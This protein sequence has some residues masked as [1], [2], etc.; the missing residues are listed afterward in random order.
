VDRCGVPPEPMLSVAFDAIEIVGPP[1]D[2]FRQG[3]E[4][5]ARLVRGGED[6]EVDVDRAPSPCGAPGER[7]RTAE[8]ERDPGVVE[9][10]GDGQHLLGNS[11][12][13]APNRG[14]SRAGACRAGNWAASSSTSTS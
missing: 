5:V 14:N 1:G 8:G 7:Q 4:D 3:S 6:G 11:D 12:H 9:R 2:A 13:A 10:P